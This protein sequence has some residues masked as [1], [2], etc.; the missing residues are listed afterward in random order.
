MKEFN[1]KVKYHLDFNSIDLQFYYTFVKYLEDNN[2]S[3]NT[4]GK[5]IKNLIT[6][7]NKATEEGVNKN[8]QYKNSEFKVLSEET[9][10]IYL[11]EE[12]IDSLYKVDLSD[13]NNKH[14]KIG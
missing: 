13:G 3:V 8:L 4:I 5:H 9:I 11:T 2:Y 1:K 12:E 7:L 14:Q 6:I 10:S